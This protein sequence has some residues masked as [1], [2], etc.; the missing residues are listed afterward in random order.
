MHKRFT[1]TALLFL[2]L[3]PVLWAG[4]AIVGRLMDGVIPP[5]TLNLL[6]W[7]LALFILTPLA[8]R[9]IKPHQNALR[10]GFWRFSALGFFGMGCY[11]SFQYLAL[12]TSSPIN[13]TLVAASIPVW[14]ILVGRLFFAAEIKMRNLVGASISMLGVLLVLSR[15]E[16]ANLSQIKPVPGDGWIIVASIAWA[17]YSWLL[18]KPTEAQKSVAQDWR[19]YLWVQIAF[20]IVWSSGFTLLEW[21]MPMVSGEPPLTVVWG[22]PLWAALAFVSVGPALVAYRCWGLGVGHVGP[23]VAAIFTNLIPLFTAVISTVMLGD[24]PRWYHVVAFLLILSGIWVS[25]RTKPAA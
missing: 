22:W 15:G 18:A 10:A 21:I 2:T 4:N 11:N 5:M 12:K 24:P 3:P 9:W 23:S 7:V 17:A 20:G 8:W 13:V 14:M 16:L 1:P 6:R 19:V 25:S